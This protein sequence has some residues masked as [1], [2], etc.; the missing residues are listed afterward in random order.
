M[1]RKVHWP[2]FWRGFR[3]GFTLGPLHRFLCTHEWRP[4]RFQSLSGPTTYKCT[5]CGKAT[6]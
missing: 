6:P 5:K 4:T 1:G 3:D 2:S